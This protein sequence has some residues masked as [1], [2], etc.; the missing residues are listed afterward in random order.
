MPSTSLRFQCLVFCLSLGCAGTNATL[1]SSSGKSVRSQ[2]FDFT[3]SDLNGRPVRFSEHGGRVVAVAFWA[4]WCEPCI[5]ELRQLQEIWKQHRDK[6]FELISINVDAPDKRSGVAETAHRY[7]FL[8]PV[9]QD[10]DGEVMNQTNPKF[11][12]PFSLLLDASGNVLSI[13]QGYKP[14][15]ELLLEEEIRA[16]LGR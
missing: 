3:L 12:L 13:H 15:D 2:R 4:T 14:G 10:T 9:L 5:E 16:A 7:R 6:G 11:E 8:F 1:D